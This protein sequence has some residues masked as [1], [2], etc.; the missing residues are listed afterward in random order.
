MVVVKCLSKVEPQRLGKRSKKSRRKTERLMVKRA[1]RLITTRATM[2]MTCSIM[3]VMTIRMRELASKL[4]LRIQASRML[5]VGLL[6][7]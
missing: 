5:R 7:P 6:H 1:K 4:R 2:A 3:I